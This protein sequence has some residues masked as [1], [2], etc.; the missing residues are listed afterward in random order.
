MED[1][2]LKDVMMLSNLSNGAK[3]LYTYLFG[4]RSGEMVNNEQFITHNVAVSRAM[5]NN[6]KRELKKLGLIHENKDGETN[7]RF[8]YIGSLHLAAIVYAEDWKRIA[9]SDDE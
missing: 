8:I 5:I 4:L 3:I 7:I 9:I 2:S 6:Y 1:K